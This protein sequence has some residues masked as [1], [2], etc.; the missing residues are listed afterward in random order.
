MGSM[1]FGL[2]KIIFVTVAHMEPLGG[3]LQQAFVVKP[4]C[5][6]CRQNCRSMDPHLVIQITMPVA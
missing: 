4:L 1:S 3:S 5:G 6:D 2:T